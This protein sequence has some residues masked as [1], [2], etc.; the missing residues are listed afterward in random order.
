MKRISYRCRLLVG[1]KK[2]SLPQSPPQG[3][4]L[5]VLESVV[6]A[7]RASGAGQNQAQTIARCSKS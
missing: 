5:Q 1:L 3:V 4:H 7:Q 2:V 6:V